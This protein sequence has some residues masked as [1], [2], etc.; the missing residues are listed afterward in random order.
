MRLEKGL[1]TGPAPWRPR[2]LKKPSQRLVR[3]NNAIRY[4]SEP[5]VRRRCRE[6]TRQRPDAADYA[7]AG[8]HHAATALCFGLCDSAQDRDFLPY[9]GNDVGMLESR[10]RNIVICVFTAQHFGAGVNLADA[11]GRVA[12][13]AA[14][15]FAARQYAKLVRNI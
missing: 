8:V 12:E 9:V 10:N 2:P 15:Y 4:E 1:A 13:F 7:R 14:N 5:P 6:Q 11:I 3:N